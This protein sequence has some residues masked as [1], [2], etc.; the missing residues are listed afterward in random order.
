MRKVVV[1]TAKDGYVDVKG[2]PTC[3]FGKLTARSTEDAEHACPTAIVGRG[4]TTAR[5]AF[6]EQTPFAAKGAVVAFNGGENAGVVTLFIH[7]YLAVPAPTAVVTTVKIHK[8]HNGAYGLR[9][10]ATIPVIAGGAGSL[11][12]FD[13]TLHRDF[14][15]HGERRSF[16]EGE[17]S[18]DKLLA[19]VEDMFADGTRAAGTLVRPCRVRR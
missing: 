18:H 3:T 19:H 9:S 4:Q 8:I 11:V 13:L 14:V 12:D 5:V 15:F 16:L 6:P 2:L 10:I 7:A 17:C 1:E